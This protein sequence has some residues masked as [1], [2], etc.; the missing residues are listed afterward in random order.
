MLDVVTSKNPFQ[1]RKLLQVFTSLFYDSRHVKRGTRFLYNDF[2][3]FV[4]VK[5]VVYVLVHICEYLCNFF[6]SVCPY[7]QDAVI[8]S[9]QNYPRDVPLICGYGMSM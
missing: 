3:F 1:K 8:F 5:V 6:P 4:C 9:S 2:F 7:V